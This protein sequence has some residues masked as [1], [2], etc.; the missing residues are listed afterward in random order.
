MSE[1]LA[2]DFFNDLTQAD[3]EA[4]LGQDAVP[5]EELRRLLPTCGGELRPEL[6]NLARVT[7]KTGEF[8]EFAA[9]ALP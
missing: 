1:A 7:G 2:L 4:H 9:F 5:V 3:V 8:R 6:R